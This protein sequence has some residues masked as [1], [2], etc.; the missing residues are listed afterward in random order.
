MTKHNQYNVPPLRF[1]EFNGE[2]VEKKLG[3]ILKIG[4]GKD[5]KHLNKGDIPVYG[6]GGYMT[7]VDDYLYDG[8]SVCIGR[9]GTID[10]PRFIDG[11]FWTVD[12][13]FYS[14]SFEQSLPKFV[15]LLFQNINWKKYNEASGVPSLSKTTIEKI[16]LFIPSTS[17]QNQ[18][19]KFLCAVDERI[20]LLQ[21][22]KAEL[23][24][25]KKGAMQKIFSKTPSVRF[26]DDNGEDF[27][28]W[29]EKIFNDVY[30]FKT[31]NSFSR[32]KL[33][34]KNGSV[35][36][37]HYGDI[38][39]KFYSLFNIE[40]EYVPFI[41]KDIDISKIPEDC[42]LQEGD[43]VIADASEDYKDIGK[44]IEIQSI[45][46]EQLVAGLHTFLAR[47]ESDEIAKG[48]A[49]FLMKS[50]KVRLEIMKIAQGTKVLGISKGRLGLIPL[51]LPTLPEQ[52]K[53]TNFLTLIDQSIQNISQQ[54]DDSLAFK[55]SLLQ[56]MFT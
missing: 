11:K 26:K 14:H 51:L 55:Q 40:K 9:K 39:T 33:N 44:T 43:L 53:I 34:Y 27:P 24:K 36:N 29:Q 52:I 28:D 32:D 6:T 2:W 10:K 21:K 49:S 30:S 4:S 23:I 35:K 47:K 3:S 54:I 8:E 56:K 38:H 7:S 31:T 19:A 41:N 42:Y 17:E 45:S 37:I 5:Y 12:T 13:L 25:Y 18:I 46:G 15:F 20:R 48:F 50:Y 22:K 16:K 1:P